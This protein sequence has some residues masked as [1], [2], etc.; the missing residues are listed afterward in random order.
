VRVIDRFASWR[1]TYLRELGDNQSWGLGEMVE[2]VQESS[3]AVCIPG[4][5]VQYIRFGPLFSVPG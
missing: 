2:V 4:W 3:F 1:A 5:L